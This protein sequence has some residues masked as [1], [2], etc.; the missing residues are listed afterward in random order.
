MLRS[1]SSRDE[2]QPPAARSGRGDA[3]PDGAG[4]RVVTLWDDNVER[5]GRV[6]E[7]VARCG[8]RLVEPD[9]DASPNQDNVR[10]ALVA[11]LGSSGVLPQD[12]ETLQRANALG[13][14]VLAY[15]DGISAWNVT[16]QC[17]A[18][19]LGACVLVD[20][21]QPDFDARLVRELGSV[22]RELTA[23]R[24]ERA[25]L[26]E[27]FARLGLVAESRAM[28]R[29]FRLI[30]RLAQL[31]DLPVLISGESGTGKELVARAI[32]RLDARRAS[33]PFIAVNCAAISAGLAESELFGHKRGAFTGADR[34]RKGLLRAAGGGVLFL[35]E[36]SE[37]SLELQAKLLR[38]LQEGR[39]ISVGDEREEPLNARVLAASNRD[40]SAMVAD[41]R[42]RS[43]LFHRL[44]VIRVRVPAVRDRPEDIEPLVRH[45]IRKH[46]SLTAEPCVATREFSEA[47]RRIDL[48]GNARQLENIVR[49]ALVR[50]AV[51]E[52]LGLQDLSTDVWQQVCACG[53]AHETKPHES[54]PRPGLVGILSSNGWNLSKSLGH[55]EREMIRAALTRSNGN[56]S[57][58]AHL[59]G[60]TPRSIYNK[61]HRPS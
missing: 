28:L 35:D 55:C 47:L 3:P 44:N 52:P 16:D 17:R 14:K 10:I 58:A 31:S 43:D 8:A 23:A 60:I 37:M 36:I 25:E 30:L 4:D 32:H 6:A 29:L 2:K 33:G 38:V 22:L 15:G 9:A 61:L 54:D 27:R 57:R 11:V 7:I 21:A 19:L 51:G 34:E 41:G 48:P 18:L 46:Q 45:F 24:A 20:S 1:A 12:V 49:Q 56:Q 40:L 39:V 5:H 42:F 50:K 26:K 13:L 53:S 59:L